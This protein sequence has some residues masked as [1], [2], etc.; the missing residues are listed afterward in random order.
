VSVCVPVTEHLGASGLHLAFRSSLP[1]KL[2]SCLL[3]YPLFSEREFPEKP[4]SLN[5]VEIRKYKTTPGGIYP[6]K[7]LQS[8]PHF[9]G[10]PNHLTLFLFSVEAQFKLQSLVRRERC[11]PNHENQPT[12][13]WKFPSFALS[14]FNDDT[15]RFSKSS[16]LFIP[17]DLFSKGIPVPP[18]S[19]VAHSLC[20]LLSPPK[21]LPC[22]S[23][24]KCYLLGR[25]LV[26]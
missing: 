13:T 20:T 15:F 11:E 14:F 22:Q 19:A 8:S 24:R 26:T 4:V 6:A 23:G 16:L 2:L 25:S 1:P 17:F 10:A 9:I 5:D 21:T 18:A 7:D 3:L 12:Q